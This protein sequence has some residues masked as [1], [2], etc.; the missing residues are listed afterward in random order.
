MREL[1]DWPAIELRSAREPHPP[2]SG[3]SPI[4]GSKTK[5][6][7]HGY[8]RPFPGHPAPTA[9]LAIALIALVALIVGGFI[10]AGVVALTSTGAPKGPQ[11]HSDWCSPQRGMPDGRR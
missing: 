2:Q 3:M 4:R 1:R 10:G 7:S 9:L 6:V 11:R 5:G 8:T